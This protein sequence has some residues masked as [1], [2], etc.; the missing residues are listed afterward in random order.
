VPHKYLGP[1]SPPL[2]MVM[3]QHS[4]YRHQP[5]ALSGAQQQ[6][7]LAAK[8]EATALSGIVFLVRRSAPGARSCHSRC[9]ADVLS[10][11]LITMNM[12]FS[13]MGGKGRQPLPDTVRAREGG[14][15]GRHQWLSSVWRW[16]TGAVCH[17]TAHHLP[18]HAAPSSLKQTVAEHGGRGTL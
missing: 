18:R 12:H 16:K 17:A 6:R 8:R 5:P 14:G 10:L 2:L 4:A 13:S 15:G 7:L 3:P 1:T 11:L 9:A